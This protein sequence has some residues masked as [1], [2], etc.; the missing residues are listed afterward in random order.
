MSRWRISWCFKPHAGHIFQ[1]KFCIADGHPSP[2]GRAQIFFLNTTC[3]KT[4]WALRKIEEIHQLMQQQRNLCISQKV[5][6]W[7]D[8]PGP[9][10]RSFAAF[11]IGE[12]HGAVPKVPKMELEEV[13]WAMDSWVKI[14][15]LRYLERIYKHFLFFSSN[16]V[17]YGWM[18]FCDF[19]APMVS[20][21]QY[22]KHGFPY[23]VTTNMRNGHVT[24]QLG[25]VK[26]VFFNGREARHHLQCEGAIVDPL[27]SKPTTNTVP[28]VPFILTGVLFSILVFLGFF[29][30]LMLTPESSRNWTTLDRFC[31]WQPW[32]LGSS[33]VG[34][35]EDLQNNEVLQ[36]GVFRHRKFQVGCIFGAW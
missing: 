14:Y 36:V 31:T 18:M 33:E 7:I 2:K 32:F 34:K 3:E 5:F 1:E 16:H 20:V 23:H 4:T 35:V 11:G 24:P 17:K 19:V 10:D 13:H 22:E 9:W 29:G 28:Y 15:S 25:F 8:P 12:S 27:R 30:C 6:A 26:R 21:H